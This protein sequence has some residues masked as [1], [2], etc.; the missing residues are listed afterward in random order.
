MFWSESQRQAW[1][2]CVAKCCLFLK[3][4]VSRGRTGLPLDVI[5]SQRLCSEQEGP[6]TIR[7]ESHAFIPLCLFLCE[8]PDTS[9]SIALT[10]IAKELGLEEDC[11]VG[12]GQ[13]LWTE[14]EGPAMTA[15]TASLSACTSGSLH[16]Q[17]I[18]GSIQTSTTN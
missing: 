16:T 3:Q 2:C 8:K 18:A 17:D 12:C 14:V 1:L 11:E 10:C 7:L 6:G 15:I 4:Q 5:R 9:K 13:E